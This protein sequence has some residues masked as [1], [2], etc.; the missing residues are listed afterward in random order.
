[1]TAILLVPETLQVSDDLDVTVHGEM[2]ILRGGDA[3]VVVWNGPLRERFFA[4]LVLGN[5]FI[6]HSAFGPSDF[7]PSVF[8]RRACG[9]SLFRRTWVT[10]LVG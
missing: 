4:R 1:M 2:L 6:G 7:R 5:S 8:R 10:S 3:A 9:H